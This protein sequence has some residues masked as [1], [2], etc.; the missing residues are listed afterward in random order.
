MI[1]DDSELLTQSDDGVLEFFRNEE[2]A[3]EVVAF[4]VCDL[5]DDAVVSAPLRRLLVADASKSPRSE[6]ECFV[7][8]LEILD[9]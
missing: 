3:C 2:S 1:S 4:E 8:G 6:A 5:G 9:S 7:V